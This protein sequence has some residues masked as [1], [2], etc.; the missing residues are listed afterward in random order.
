M[1]TINLADRYERPP[2]DRDSIR[3]RL[4]AGIEEDSG[5]GG[6]DRNTRG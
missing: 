3:K 2:I 1:D 5:T 4:D 6:L